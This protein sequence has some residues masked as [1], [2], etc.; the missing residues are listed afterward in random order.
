MRGPDRPPQP[1]PGVHVHLL[2]FGRRVAVGVVGGTVIMAGVAML[3]LPGPGLVTIA[4]G[5]AILSLEFERPRA[6]L[7]RMKARG[8]ALK[9]RLAAAPDRHGRRE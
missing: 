8:V 7:A 4:L 5:L 1:P 9:D 3:A 6:W 2:R